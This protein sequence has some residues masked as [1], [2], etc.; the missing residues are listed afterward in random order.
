MYMHMHMHMYMHMYMF[1]RPFSLRLLAQAL[2]VLTLGLY[3]PAKLEKVCFA[4]SAL[5]RIV[6]SSSYEGR[7]P[8]PIAQRYRPISWS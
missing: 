1:V 6:Q 5:I 7:A 2:P 3:R 4:Y 8:W